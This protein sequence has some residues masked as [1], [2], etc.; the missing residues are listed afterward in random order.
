MKVAILH[1]KARQVLRSFP[2][3]ARREMGKAIFDL[4]KGNS[5]GM[6]L[7]KPMPDVALGVEELRV[8][9]ASGIYR[10]FYYKKSKQ[11]ILILHAFGKKSQKTPPRE[12][13]I[14]R[15]RLKEMLNEEEK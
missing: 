8:Q 3:E 4:Q 9:D 7:S 13:E 12:M 1:P 11:G 5:L 14:A 10:T 6:P 2:E 15:K